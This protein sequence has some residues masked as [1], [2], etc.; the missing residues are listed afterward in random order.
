MYLYTLSKFAYITKHFNQKPLLFIYTTHY[1][2]MHIKYL[3]LR[4][5]GLN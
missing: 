2:G 3:Y 5:K 4:F 1:A